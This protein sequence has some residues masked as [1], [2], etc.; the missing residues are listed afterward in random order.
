MIEPG[1]EIVVNILYKREV[2]QN[3]A[4]PLTVASQRII[5]PFAQYKYYWKETQ[6]VVNIPSNIIQRNLGPVRISE[7]ITNTG[8]IGRVPSGTRNTLFSQLAA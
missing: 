5:D 1:H 3:V 6:H 7:L 4:G 8:A 2:K